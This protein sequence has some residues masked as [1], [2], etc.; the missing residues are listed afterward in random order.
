MPDRKSRS[1]A[2]ALADTKPEADFD[3]EAPWREGYP[4]RSPENASSRPAILD[5]SD[6]ADDPTQWLG[7][8]QLGA[9]GARLCLIFNLMEPG[10]GPRLHRHPYPE[11][12]VIRA[13]RAVFTVGDDTVEATAGQIVVVPAGVAHKF[14]N[15]GPD[16]LETLDIH[17]SGSIDTE[18][19][20]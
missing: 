3:F 2:D 13:G 8:V 16:V 17:E 5:R 4:S 19:L 7:E 18:W 11:T 14:H 12:F 20:E 15:P 10:N 9:H 6:W 1:L